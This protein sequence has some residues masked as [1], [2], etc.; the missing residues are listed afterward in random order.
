MSVQICQDVDVIMLHIQSSV[1]LACLPL[2]KLDLSWIGTWLKI[3]KLANDSYVHFTTLAESYLNRT[4]I[5]N[6]SKLHAYTGLEFAV[7]T[8]FYTATYNRQLRS[9]NLLIMYFFPIGLYQQV[10]VGDNTSVKPWFFQLG[11]AAQWSPW[12]SRKGYV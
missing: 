7:N 11:A 1:N 3:K 5:L 4:I 9:S 2:S 8:E 6:V 12:E 10:T